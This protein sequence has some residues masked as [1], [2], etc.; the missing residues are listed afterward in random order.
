MFTLLILTVAGH[1]RGGFGCTSDV[2]SK[3]QPVETV[4]WLKFVAHRI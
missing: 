3:G 1:E 4:T 2:M